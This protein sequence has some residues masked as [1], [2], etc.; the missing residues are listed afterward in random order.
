MQ[1]HFKLNST[2]VEEKQTI[3]ENLNFVKYL[4]LTTLK[5]KKNECS[6]CV[7]LVFFRF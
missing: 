4:R 2:N 3:Y 5:C 6:K 1:L 7:S